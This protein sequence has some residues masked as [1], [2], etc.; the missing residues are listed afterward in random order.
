MAYNGPLPQVVNAGGTGA[1]TLTGVLTGNG[2][3]AV[4]ANA[5]T[6]FDVL[7]GG[8]SNAVSSVGPGS[9]GQVLQS[10]GNAANPAYST[11]TYPSTTTANQLLYSSATNVVGGLTSGNSL[12]AATNASGT[13]AM[14]AFS[15][16][17][18]KFTTTGTYTPSTG[19]LYCTIEVVGGGGG[20]GGCSTSAPG[21][22]SGSGG[23]G[24]GGYARLTTSAA[25]I[26]ASQ[27][28]TIGAAGTAGAAGGSD[29]GT[30]GTT[31][32]G[33]L[34]SATGGAGGG[35]SA[36][37]AFVTNFGGDGGAGSSGDFNTVGQGGGCGFGQNFGVGGFG[38]SSFF[39]GGA[40]SVVTQGSPGIAINATS[41]GGGGSGS[42]S[43]NT[44]QQAGGTGFAGIVVI[45][46]YIIN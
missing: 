20:G 38:G 15:V 17:V 4:T 7:V 41:Y 29:G 39:G 35:G 1:K 18:Q 14:R 16:N 8:A 42:S 2:T 6:Q 32:V 5:V 24:G 11:A 27:A 31:S 46:E 23:G 26:G 19:M 13:V 12:V 10:A 43:A 34:V 28:V 25:T 36:T 40:K 45:T 30:G 33:S 21:T 22:V 37:A 44:A 3:S 9:A